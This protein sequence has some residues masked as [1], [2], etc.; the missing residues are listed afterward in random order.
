[1]VW[2][3]MAQKHPPRDKH[4]EQNVNSFTRNWKLFKMYVFSLYLPLNPS[5]KLGY[6]MHP[7]DGAHSS[8]FVGCL[9]SVTEESTTRSKNV[10]SS[11]NHIYAGLV[12]ICL[13]TAGFEQPGSL[14][15]SSASCA[16]VPSA[17][18]LDICWTCSCFH[19]G[20]P[21]NG[22]SDAVST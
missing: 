10:S 13:W 15:L 8:P 7:E 18:L 12:R 6:E 3:I 4:L 5:K 1:M 20:Q 11:N 17:G 16:P 21:Q 14:S 19:A 2:G 9:C 22:I